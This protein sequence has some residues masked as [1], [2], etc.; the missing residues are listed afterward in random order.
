MEEGALQLAVVTAPATFHPQ[1]LRCVACAD[2]LDGEQCFAGP[3]DGLPYCETCYRARYERC[4]VTGAP[5][6][7]EEAVCDAYAKAARI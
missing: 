1:C 7:A 2:A 3:E 4:F 6:D 5:L